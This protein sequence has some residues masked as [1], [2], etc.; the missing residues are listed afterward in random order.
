MD[1]YST[2]MVT[3]YPEMGTVNTA[4]VTSY[5]AMDTTDT[6]KVTGHSATDTQNTAKVTTYPEMGTHPTGGSGKGATFPISKVRP[7]PSARH[8]PL[9]QRAMKTFG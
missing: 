3:S 7:S 2:A 1:T 8:L 6:A 9:D 5:P 4:K